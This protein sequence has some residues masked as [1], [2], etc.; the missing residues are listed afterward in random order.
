MRKFLVAVIVAGTMAFGG[1]QAQSEKRPHRVGAVCKDGT[2]S[3][4]TGKG[5]CSHHGG[6]KCWQFSDGTCHG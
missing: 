4:A 5:A 2:T 6:V 1:V 3:S